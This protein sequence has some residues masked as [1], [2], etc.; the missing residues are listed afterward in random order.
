MKTVPIKLAEIYVPIKHS[1]ALDEAKAESLAEDI[2]ENGLREPIHVR[3]DE[4]KN[5]YVLVTGLHRL[6]AVR[7]L[8]EITVDAL[9]VQARKY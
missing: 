8:G 4:A 2:L 3:R 9:V 6:E 5:R 1:G 7:S